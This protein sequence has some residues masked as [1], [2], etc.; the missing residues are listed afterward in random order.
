M[1]TP[2]NLFNKPVGKYEFTPQAFP[3]DEQ[4]LVEAIT[5]QL[6]QIEQKDDKIYLSEIQMKKKSVEHFKKEESARQYEEIKLINPM[7]E[8]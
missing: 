7:E 5:T 3:S 1:D 6:N 8:V 2:V 4:L